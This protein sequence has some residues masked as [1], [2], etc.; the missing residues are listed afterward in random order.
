[1]RV[2]TDRRWI[3]LLLSAALLFFGVASGDKKP[4]LKPEEVVERHLESLATAEFRAQW[5]SCRLEGAS[6]LR[7]LPILN[8]YLATKTSL[9]CE[10]RKFRMSMIFGWNR[11]PAEE[12]AYDGKR[13][14]VSHVRPGRRSALGGFIW[15]NKEILSEGLFGG[16]LSTGWTLLNLESRQP[17][18]KYGGIKK[19]D[20]EEFHLL[21]YERRKGGGVEIKLYF[22]PETFR[23]RHTTYH[24]EYG[25]LATL[26]ESFADF[27][28]G[29][30]TLPSRWIVE[31]VP[32]RLRWT[33]NFQVFFFNEEIDAGQ[34]DID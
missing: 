9:L 4:D 15:Q 22:E 25:G 30:V 26:K 11:Y 1:M 7:V 24:M 28:V 17:K 5:K 29:N 32:R 13:V 14:E 19:I 8:R 10:G 12:V 3:P 2:P 33:T 16:V 27:S 23:H 31:L 21:K 20:D 6:D 34:F 18:L